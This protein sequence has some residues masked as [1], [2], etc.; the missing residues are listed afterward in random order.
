MLDREG[1]RV[2]VCVCVSAEYGLRVEWIDRKV[3]MCRRRVCENRFLGTFFFCLDCDVES[4]SE[5]KEIRIFLIFKTNKPIS[6]SE[7]IS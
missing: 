5:W 2:C 4:F 1:E 6:R 3:R 7:S